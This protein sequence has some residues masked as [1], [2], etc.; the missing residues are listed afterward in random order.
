M[1][2]L[3]R[4]K[5]GGVLEPAT[6]Q[7]LLS[8]KWWAYIA[9]AVGLFTS[10]ADHGS[11]VVALPTISEH[12]K[13]DLPTAQWVVL[14]YAVTISALLLP[15]GRLSDLVGRK[16]VYLL[17]FFV[18]IAGATAAGLATSVTVLVVVRVVMGVG[19]A[20]TQST[21]MAIVMSAFPPSER[22]KALGLQIS[23]VGLGGVAG[24]AIGG[25]IVGFAGWRGVFFATA[26]MGVLAIVAAQTLLEERASEKPDETAGAGFDWPGAVLSAVILVTFLVALTLGPRSNWSP[27]T[28][29]AAV[30]SFVVVLGVF[31]WWELRARSPM[32]DPRLFQDMVFSIGVAAR[33][34]A[35]IG[36]SSVRFLMPFYLQSVLGY[37]PR[38]IGLFVV[39]SALALVLTGPIGGRLSDRYGT[40]VLSSAGL[41]ISAAG[42]L[43]LSRVSNASPLPLII[44]AM[45]VQSI[46]SGIFGPPNSSSIFGAVGPERYGVMSGF[47]N[48]VR[49]AGNVTGV[50]LA[51]AIVTAVMASRGFEPS[52]AAVS[53]TGGADLLGAFVSGLRG[54][55]LLTAGLVAL[56][57]VLSALRAGRPLEQQM[58]SAPDERQA[59]AR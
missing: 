57:A 50:A 11:V 53:E 1:L 47:L 16:R 49:N 21:S 30:L 23:I 15:M 3:P 37:A 19:A 13:I 28:T 8:Y 17:G 59:A 27:T 33:F 10:V 12:F 4:L 46:G 34:I 41:L 39:P 5:G 20:M 2:S 38:A 45:V 22:G 43:I 18:F 51:T 35:F 7:R 24:P 54:A 40:R 56:G 14:G 44:G 52:L 31:V 48:L 55:Y 36:I 32:L 26:A 9:V 42:L 58:V 25:L 29:G 6:Q